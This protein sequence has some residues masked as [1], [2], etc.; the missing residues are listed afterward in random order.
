MASPA[1]VDAGPS[2]NTGTTTVDV[3][4]MATVNSNDY[5]MLHI[6]IRAIGGSANTPDGWSLVGSNSSLGWGSTFIFERLADGSE[7]SSTV[8]V[9]TTGG[10]GN[11]SA[12]IYRFSGVSPTAPFTESFDFGTGTSATIPDV[13]VIALG[14]ARLAVNFVSLPASTTTSSFTGE[15]GG[16]WTEAVAENANGVDLTQQIQT[17]AIPKGTIDGGTF[18]AGA[19]SNFFVQGLALIPPRGY[20]LKDEFEDGKLGTPDQAPYSLPVSNWPCYSGRIVRSGYASMRV[21]ATGAARAIIY[22]AG[23]GT[24]ERT[25]VGSFYVRVDLPFT[26]GTTSIWATFTDPN[27]RSAGI[28]CETVSGLQYWQSFTAD[29]SFSSFAQYNGTNAPVVWGKWTL[30]DFKFD[31][32]AN[33]WTVD[34]SV[35][36]V[37]QTQG[38]RA[39][40]AE[41]L[42]Q[43]DVGELDPVTSD[44]YFDSVW[45][46]NDA[47]V[48][49]IGDHGPAVLPRS[50]PIPIERGKGS[51]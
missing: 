8:S 6:L 34:F 51:C 36:G 12:R 22:I 31:L 44:V 26:G 27:N 7:G 45:L 42:H 39:F 32:T 4:C 5:L 35:D 13:A 3:Q 9:T 21:N 46:N 25:L 14:D 11:R 19:S 17:A 33:P 48:Y 1:F 49:P 41:D 16:D 18:T 37:A 23:S 50:I 20:V 30:I 28:I 43:N 29:T 10:A 38:T 47:S 24:N 2:Q 40:A 15:T